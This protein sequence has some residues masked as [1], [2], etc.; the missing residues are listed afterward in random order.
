[1]PHSPA[2][3]KQVELAGGWVEQVELAGGWVERVKARSSNLLDVGGRRV[4]LLN[5]FQR[6]DRLCLLLDLPLLVRLVRTAAADA[7]E[8]KNKDVQQTDDA[9]RSSSDEGELRLPRGSEDPLEVP[10]GEITAGSHEVHSNEDVVEA[11]A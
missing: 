7:R 1:M 2:G 9:K 8:E 11:L 6:F 5:N 10:E 4:I 3:Y